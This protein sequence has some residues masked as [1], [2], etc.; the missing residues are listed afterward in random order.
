MSLEA[1]IELLSARLETLT[2]HIEKL[3]AALYTGE[4]DLAASGLYAGEEVVK[5][6]PKAKVE[7][8]V[9]VNDDLKFTEPTAEESEPLDMTGEPIAFED[10][11]RLCLDAA[12]DPKIGK[13]KVKEVIAS[14]GAK[15]AVD[16]KENERRAVLDAI[17]V[18]F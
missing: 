18:P 10:F 17:G 4:K 12:R 9:L 1:K 16:V 6:Q 2:G 5:P 8:A 14:F 11:R 13:E 15:K 7:K 3:T